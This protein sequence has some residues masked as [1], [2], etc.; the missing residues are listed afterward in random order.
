MHV[1]HDDLF[2]VFSKFICSVL[3]TC[4]KITSGTPKLCGF[5][6]KLGGKEIYPLAEMPNLKS[7]KIWEIAKYVTFLDPKKVVQ[8]RDLLIKS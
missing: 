4:Q 1:P 7:P 6:N 2:Q 5:L 3:L 8:N